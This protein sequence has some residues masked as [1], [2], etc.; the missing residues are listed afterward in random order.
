MS[1][2]KTWLHNFLDIMLHELRGI[3]KDVGVLI[4]FF[5]G[6]LGY[7]IVYSLVYHNGILEDTPIAVVDDSADPYSRRYIREL[8]ATR[9]VSVA[10]SCVNME[11]ARSLLQK[12]KVN[13]IVY[14]PRDFGEK[15]VRGETA[16]LSIYAD[17][18]SFL[19]YKNLL[20]GA[21]FVMLDEI[22]NI[23]IERFSAAGYSGQTLSQLVEPMKY[24]DNNP[25][26]RAFSYG[27]FF[28][29]AAL[30]L[31]IQQTMFYGMSLRAGTMREESHSPALLPSVVEGSGVGRVVLGRGA[32]YWLLYMGIGMYIAFII[33]AAFGLP[34]RGDFWDIFILLLFFITDCVLFCS[35]WSSL[36][37]RRETVFVLFLFMS[38]I[39]LF[40]TGFSWPTSAFPAFW[41]YFSYIFPSTF[42]CQA[43]INLNTAGGD[44]STVRELIAALAVQT[45][46]YY[47]L[48]SV[49]IYVENWIIRHKE[50]LQQKRTLV[51]ERIGRGLGDRVS[52]DL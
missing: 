11:E 47:V 49:A 46:V 31:V 30:L 9:E 20:M 34:Q 27:I 44:L 12:R 32:A 19:Y 41:R 7:P 29:S 13:G 4:I 18:S 45:I 38:P 52:M 43:F 21:N 42:G 5:V 22:K 16:K 37:T 14:F 17:M 10:Y 51:E 33:P 50:L 24:E 36:I 28:L 48:S 15:V 35:T 39:A 8:D 1:F 23:Q 3:F 40:L 26:N 6:G 25:Y 2:V